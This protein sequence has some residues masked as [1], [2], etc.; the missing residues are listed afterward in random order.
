MSPAQAARGGGKGL[1]EAA[2]LTEQGSLIVAEGQ[3]AKITAGGVLD[4]S[5]HA[6]HAGQIQLYTARRWP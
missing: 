6:G 5:A 1:I 3:G 2:T 4:A